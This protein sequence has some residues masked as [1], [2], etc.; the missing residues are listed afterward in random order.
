MHVAGRESSLWV[1]PCVLALG[2]VPSDPALGPDESVRF[3]VPEAS[4]DQWVGV[5]S[6]PETP[7]G[8]GMALVG[9][10]AWVIGGE[11]GALNPQKTS[12]VW[13]ICKTSPPPT[14]WTVATPLPTPR[15][16]F[17][18]VGVINRKIYVAG[19][20]DA[21]GNCMSELYVYSAATGWVLDAEPMPFRAS[22]GAAAVVGNKLYVYGN[23][24][25]YPNQTDCQ[26]RSLSPSVF[27]VYNP[28]APQPPRWTV[29]SPGQN[30][31][32]RHYPAVTALG[33]RI[34]VFGGK[35]NYLL[36]D[37]EVFE[38]ATNQW[39]TPAPIPGSPFTRWAAAAVS[40]L[41]RLYYIGGING[42][43]SGLIGSWVDVYDSTTGTWDEASPVPFQEG[44]VGAVAGSNQIVVLG[45]PRS[46]PSNVMWL[47]LGKGTAACD[48]HEPNDD[49]PKAQIWRFRDDF[50]DRPTS[51]IT[52]ARMCSATDVDLYSFY[53]AYFGGTVQLTPP[54]GTDY[55]LE[56]L[57]STGTQV[58]AISNNP[59][60]SPE[61]VSFAQHSTG[62][63]RVTSQNGSFD[64][65]RPY[66]L[67]T[68]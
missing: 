54:P 33:S 2:C 68:Q 36:G 25:F 14:S 23:S 9:N 27:A 31:T 38:T 61:S 46:A 63:L 22:R 43:L 15:A 59:G 47:S 52:Q 66:R 20:E 56:L 24:T 21:A 62:I 39:I 10:C 17:A 67:E 3:S 53:S 7:W 13:T 32:S 48:S 41:G 8:F 51:P 5:P 6:V 65:V 28:S 18:G 4:L 16:N 26:D 30:P 35:G 40:A 29:L 1:I 49:V 44:F 55:Q 19:G 12:D 57:D 34:Y 64:R 11:T 50:S 45:S 58:L 60:S 37:T 42:Y